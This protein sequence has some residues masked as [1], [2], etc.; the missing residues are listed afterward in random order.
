MSKLEPKQQTTREQ[1]REE[2]KKLVAHE[3][4]KIK[5]D[6]TGLKK[7]YNELKDKAHEKIKYTRDNLM[8]GVSSPVGFEENGNK[9]WRKHIIK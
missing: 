7:K 3:R 5:D 9:L 1:K 8:L 6:F 2:K 4:E